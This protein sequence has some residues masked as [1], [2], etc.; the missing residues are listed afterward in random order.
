MRLARDG[1]GTLCTKTANSKM[2]INQMTGH[3]WVLVSQESA[4]A[5]PHSFVWFSSLCL[6]SRRYC[7]RKR[8]PFPPAS[9]AGVLPVTSV[10][11]RRLPEPPCTTSA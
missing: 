11:V 5:L 9:W 7:A 6:Y 2:M 4:P 3:S 8:C 10:A 1:L